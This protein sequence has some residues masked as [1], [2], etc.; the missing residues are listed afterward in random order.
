MKFS[1]GQGCA[2]FIQALTSIDTLFANDFTYRGLE[3]DLKATWMV[4]VGRKFQIH[5]QLVPSQRM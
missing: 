2:S 4:T 3:V 5:Q 1:L